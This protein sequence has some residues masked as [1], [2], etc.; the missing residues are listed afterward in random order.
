MEINKILGKNEIIVW[1]GR[2]NAFLF[3]IRWLFGMSIINLFLMFF[4]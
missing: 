3:T 2:P 1:E 4:S